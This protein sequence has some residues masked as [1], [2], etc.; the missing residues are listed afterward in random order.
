MTEWNPPVETGLSGEKYLTVEMEETIGKAPS[1]AHR[2]GVYVLK[3]S[4]PNASREKYCRLWLADHDVVP[5][6][7]ESLLPDMNHLYYVGM[8]ENVYKRIR[9]HLEKPN[10]S[11]T[12]STT[13]PIHS[14]EQVNF[15]D[16]VQKASEKEHQIALELSH[17]HSDA[18]VHC[19]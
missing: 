1:A 11:T 18:Y 3:H 17:Q 9:E 7:V 2:P 14:V 15:Y 13:F 8:A 19:R 5:E 12:V 10:R 4:L 6:Y 16:T